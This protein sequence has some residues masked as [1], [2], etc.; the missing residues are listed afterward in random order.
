MILAENGEKIQQHLYDEMT[1]KVVKEPS[2][3]EAVKKCRDKIK[4]VVIQGLV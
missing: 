3:R 2:F 1:K 4:M